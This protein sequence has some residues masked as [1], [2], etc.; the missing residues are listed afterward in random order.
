VRKLKDSRYVEDED[1]I[2]EATDL[3]ARELKKKKVVVESTLQKDAEVTASL[4]KA[5]EIAK[6]IEVLHPA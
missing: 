5:L 2:A 6:E 3:V 1:Q 4:Q